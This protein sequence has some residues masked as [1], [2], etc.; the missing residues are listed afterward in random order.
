MRQPGLP[1]AR[2]ALVGVFIFGLLLSACGGAGAKSDL[3]GAKKYLTEK[4]KALKDASAS[5]KTVSDQYYALA[6]GASFNYANLWRDKPAD[7]TKTIQSAQ[8]AWIVAS[9]LY[10]QMEG[11]VAGVPKLSDY[12]VII[13]A[14][15]SGA[16]GGDNVVPFDL[17]LPDGRSLAKPGNLFG[18][19]ES[20]LW[21]TF[22]AYTVAD[23]KP[24]FNGNGK[25]DFGEA[26]PDANVLKGGVDELAKQS[27]ELDES[28][29]K[30]TPTESEAFGALVTMVPTMSE[31]FESWRNSRFVAGDKSEQRDF[32]AISRL[33]DI[34][35]ILSG[36][37]VVYTGLSPRVKGSDSA[38][39]KQITDGLAD[40]KSFVADIYTKEKA[41]EH[42]TAEQADQLGDET[43][44]RATAVTGLIT[45]VAAKLKVKVDQ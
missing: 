41:G 9:P 8:Q 2:L 39:D 44:N 3:T 28:A 38:Q 22:A 17:K 7:V 1:A 18:I 27:S 33:S 25:I 19:T 29:G 11:I 10:E 35:D 24:D 37:Q 14:G 43:E 12:D 32:V 4:T 26:M 36:L 31:Y 21:G 13:D 40:M 23:V 42:F 34:G 16:E 30:W 15:S 45:Q 20:T 6:Q 5:L